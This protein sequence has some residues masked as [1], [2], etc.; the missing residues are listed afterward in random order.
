LPVP[1]GS[2][3]VVRS[4]ATCGDHWYLGGSTATTAGAFSPVIW[5]STDLRSWTTLPINP[6][7][8]YGK[9]NT[10]GI[11]GCQA[12]HVA[13]IGWQ[14]GGAHGFPRYSGWFPDAAGTLQEV[15]IP[16][17]LFAGP[18]GVNLTGIAVSPRGWVLSGNRSSGAAAWHSSTGQTYTLL[19]HAPNLATSAAQYTWA[20]GVAATPTG[21]VI[22]GSVTP[23]STG[24]RDPAVWTSSDALT[25]TPVPVPGSPP[26]EDPQKVTV[27]GD[28]IVMIGLRDTGFGV[29]RGTTQGGWARVG[30]LGD[31]G[32]GEGAASALVD[33]NSHLFATISGAAY[34]LWESDDTGTN[35][36]P[37]G[38]PASA[39]NKADTATFVVSDQRQLLLVIDDGQ[40]SR[41]W[42]DPD[43]AA[44]R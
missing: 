27:V 26:F 19:D 24:N 43:A 18:E 21:W 11:L 9:Q 8:Y 7:S 25:W 34:S 14:V 39:P 4:S 3:A 1:A 38:L 15:D 42:L 41:A 33:T 2:R 44:G 12:G 13:A 32:E 30:Q 10:I 31:N 37:L 20:G 36:H 22:I 17:T 35:W 29:W 16:Y 6:V 28:T 5:T 23:R 40:S